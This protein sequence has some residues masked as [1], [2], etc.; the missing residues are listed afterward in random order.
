MIERNNLTAHLAE[1]VHTK[2]EGSV[3]GLAGALAGNQDLVH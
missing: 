3:D 2:I 1:T